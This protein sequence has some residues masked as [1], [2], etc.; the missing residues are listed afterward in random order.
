MRLLS[1]RVSSCDRHRRISANRQRRHLSDPARG[2]PRAGMHQ[3]GAGGPDAPANRR[4]AELPL[5]SLADVLG[6]EDSGERWEHTS[7]AGW[8]RRTSATLHFATTE[9]APAPL[10][11]AP[12]AHGARGGA[13]V[14]RSERGAPEK[15]ASSGAGRKNTA[16]TG[17]RYLAQ[18]VRD[19]LAGGPAAVVLGSGTGGKAQLVAACSQPAVALGVTAL[20]LL[21][22][23]APIRWRCA[24]WQDKLCHK[25]EAQPPTEALTQKH[26]P[27][28][29]RASRSS[30]PRAE[31]W[32][33]R[34][35]RADGCWAS[36][37]AP[38]G[39]AWRSATRIGGWPCRWEPSTWANRPGSSSP[40]AI[41]SRST[42][43]PRSSWAGRDRSP[44]GAAPARSRPRRSRR[45]FEVC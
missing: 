36:I 18:K 3:I 33:G 11:A 24:E 15:V 10:T 9:Q 43:S 16:T 14:I 2:L 22:T 35:R 21:V 17:L 29:R 1:L 19:K 39:S 45:R 23:T 20:R 34:V 5:R 26:S 42:R 7:T 4:R 32:T 13:P 6:V 25:P 30:W 8:S 44:A 37:W 41:S 38:P 31:S 27:G 12:A 28:S 40:C